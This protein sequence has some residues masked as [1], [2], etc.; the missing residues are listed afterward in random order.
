M[1]RRPGDWS[2]LPK[3]S[4]FARGPLDSLASWRH[5][6]AEKGASH[7]ADWFSSA[8][9][10]RSSF[11]SRCWGNLGLGRDKVK[12]RDISVVGVPPK[13]GWRVSL[14]HDR[15]RSTSARP[16][17]WDGDGNPLLP[18]SL[19][20]PTLAC[21]G[22]LSVAMLVVSKWSAERPLN[23]WL[24]AD[25]SHREEVHGCCSKGGRG[26]KVQVQLSGQ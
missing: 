5:G 26:R 17:R 10:T 4:Q 19:S 18:L 25:P 2:K 24:R 7:W 15:V 21:G 1:P 8:R 9:G 3:P 11:D 13:G 22:S 6:R 12:R 16:S 20:G 14:C 23:R